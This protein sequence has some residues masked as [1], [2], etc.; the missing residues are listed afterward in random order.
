MQQGYGTH[1]TLSIRI[2]AVTINRKAGLSRNVNAD[3]L[4]SS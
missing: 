1:K 2:N 4:N 3:Q